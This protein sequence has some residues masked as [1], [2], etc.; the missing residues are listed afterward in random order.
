MIM[1]ALKECSRLTRILP[2][3]LPKRN[4]IALGYP[5]TRRSLVPCSSCSIRSVYV[6]SSNVTLSRGNLL[7]SYSSTSETDINVSR[8]QL[9]EL[10]ASRT[11]VVID[12]REP[13]ELREHGNIPG[14]V[15]IPLGQVNQAL[16]L[17]PEEFKEK[18]VREKPS[19][20][21]NIVFSCMAG[22]RS[23]TALDTAVSLGYSNVQ[24]YPGGWQDWANN[25]PKH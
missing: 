17:T 9:K 5:R 6:S 8:E 25:Q 11:G 20:S 3:I 24:H 15:N 18:Y 14:T 23:K 2:L 4:F 19:H 21:D 7:R 13:W 1:M 10:L 16:Q 12:V 22:I